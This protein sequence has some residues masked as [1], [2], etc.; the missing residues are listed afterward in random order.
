MTTSSTSDSRE[1]VNCSLLTEISETFQTGTFG[2][3]FRI[4]PLSIKKFLRR[5]VKVNVVSSQQAVAVL[6]TKMKN[7]KGQK[8]AVF[9]AATGHRLL[10]E[11]GKKQTRKVLRTWSAMQV[12]TASDARVARWI[13]ALSCEKTFSLVFLNESAF[14]QSVLATKRAVR[15]Y[16]FLVVRSYK[17][18]GLSFLDGIGYMENACRNA[19]FMPNCIEERKVRSIWL[20]SS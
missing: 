1:H 12:Y 5:D 15:K 16:Q 9:S 3:K 8:F 18:G 19:V 10:H 2:D 20:L 11:A 17:H 14:M 4:S 6:E 13:F 7:R